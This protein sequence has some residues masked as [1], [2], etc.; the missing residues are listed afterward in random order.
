MELREFV[1]TSLVDIMRGIQDAQHEIYADPTAKGAVNPAFGRLRDTMEKV[2]FDVAVT[3]GSEASGEGKGGIN[4]M[5]ANLSG[6][7]AGKLHDS[8]VSRL[9]FSVP[10]APSAQPVVGDVA[11]P[12]HVLLPQAATS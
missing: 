9:T 7:V 10:I 4:V 11:G 1:R 5:A 6:K 8:S 2:T 3:A 12:T